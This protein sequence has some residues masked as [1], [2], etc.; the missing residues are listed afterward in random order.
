M[1]SAR[2]LATA[3]LG[4]RDAP[5]VLI[6]GAVRSG[7]TRAGVYGYGYW[8]A[9]HFE[10]S[11]FLLAAQTLE[12][13]QINLVPPLVELAEEVGMHV[14]V[15]DREV[16][17][18]SNKVILR[19]GSTA[20]AWRRLRGPTLQGAL[21][22]EITLLHRTFVAEVDL[23]CSLPE[24][25][26]IHMTNPDSPKH[27]WK[28]QYLDRADE[29]GYEH[30]HFELSDN[31]TLDAAYIERIKRS[32]FGPF[33]R[34]AVYGEWVGV[35]GLVWPVY[36]VSDPP[37]EPPYSYELVIDHA[38]AGVTAA[39]LFGRYAAGGTWAIDEY[40]YNGRT[41]GH[42]SDGELADGIMQML[43][44]RSPRGCVV[45]ASALSMMAEM[46][47]RLPCPIIPADKEIIPGIE[48]TGAW[49]ESGYVQI[50]PWCTGVQGDLDSYEWDERAA[51]VGV[52]KPLKTPLGEDHYADGF[53]YYC[54][55]RAK[56]AAG[57][58]KLVYAA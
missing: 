53:R 30:H 38:T 50:A 39:I 42:R 25:K 35:E 23:R 48:L 19:G 2:Q 7:K 17:F 26:Q 43:G 3:T 31:P 46:R 29:L 57:S 20:D 55:T 15:R 6:E 10:R 5:V 41:G 4:R 24:S 9:E 47:T 14:K 11:L 52:S 44:S 21:C 54:Y 12:L 8:I 18:G 34:R 32:T 56:A 40:R 16:E 51:L 1:W 45:D 28:T 33:L 36:H 22:D 49:L 13:V 58:R 27:W 37:D